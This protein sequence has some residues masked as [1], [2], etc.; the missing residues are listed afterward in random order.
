[1]ENREFRLTGQGILQREQVGP[2]SGLTSSLFG[3]VAHSY[4]REK[5]VK[6]NGELSLKRATRDIEAA[7]GGT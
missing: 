1:M 4:I 6:N 3:R 2:N 7:Y 5:P